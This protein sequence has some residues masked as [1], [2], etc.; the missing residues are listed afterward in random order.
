MT[1]IVRIDTAPGQGHKNL[2]E[3]LDYMNT[4]VLVDGIETKLSD[5]LDRYRTTRERNF[6]IIRC[7]ELSL[8]F[9]RIM[10]LHRSIKDFG[11]KPHMFINKLKKDIKSW[12]MKVSSLRNCG[13]ND[14]WVLRLP[15][16]N[17]KP[18]NKTG[19]SQIG[20][21]MTA[22]FDSINDAGENPLTVNGD[23]K[24]Y[25]LCRHGGKACCLLTKDNIIGMLKSNWNVTNSWELIDPIDRVALCMKNKRP[26]IVSKMIGLKCPMIACDNKDGRDKCGKIIRLDKMITCIPRHERK[27]LYPIGKIRTLITN[28]VAVNEPDRVSY[29][30][31]NTCECAQSGTIVP[32]IREGNITDSDMIYCN[33]CGFVHHVHAHKIKCS[34][35]NTNFCTVCRMRPY[36]DEAVCQ[37]KKLDPDMSDEEW[38][39]LTSTTRPCAHCNVRTNKAGG[40]DH[41]RCSSCGGHWCWRCL[42]KLDEN[43][44]YNHQCL[45]EQVVEGGPDMNY[46]PGRCAYCEERIRPGAP[47]DCQNRRVLYGERVRRRLDFDDDGF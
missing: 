20:K 23:E 19:K 11:E 13:K 2:Q 16:L 28:L 32:S 3:F 21:I 5:C 47:H 24:S 18:S 10:K 33:T 38:K 43:N 29:C 31:L 12:N 8:I 22:G 30:P 45:G 37:G 36:H 25:S 26:H 17:T 42:Q 7:K 39:A 9:D 4:C 15:S 41:I 27:G 46:D 35:C 40:C 1:D 14:D 6:Y 34:G 44:P